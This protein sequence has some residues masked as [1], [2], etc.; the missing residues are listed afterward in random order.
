MDK[1]LIHSTSMVKVIVSYSDLNYHVFINSDIWM[2]H[3]K[4]MFNR[5]NL[6]KMGC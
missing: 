4:W 1:C 2:F 5:S 3:G 6:V